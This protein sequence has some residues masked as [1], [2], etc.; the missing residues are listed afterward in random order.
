M[1]GFMA[2]AIEHGVRLWRGVEVTGID[3]DARGVAGV[4]TTNG[5]VAARTVV[6][7]AGPWAA[8]VAR[9]AGIDLPIVP[10][11]PHAGADRAFPRIA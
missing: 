3:V 6:N 2:G 1:K 10:D 5:D 4:R 9:M 11:A 7:A 8:G